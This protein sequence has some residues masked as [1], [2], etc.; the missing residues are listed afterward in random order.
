M[1][2]YLKPQNET[3]CL[4]QLSAVT[5][6]T[7]HACNHKNFIHLSFSCNLRLIMGD[8]EMI[9][10]NCYRRQYPCLT[11]RYDSIVYKCLDKTVPS[12]VF[13]LCAQREQSH[14][15]VCACLHGCISVCSF[16]SCE[17]MGSSRRRECTNPIT[18][19]DLL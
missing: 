6:K 11:Q 10:L 4:I 1:I 7:L 12:S 9:I 19:S 16:F 5:D 13:Y 17:E 2:F 18:Y 3:R 14:L 15:H 8:H